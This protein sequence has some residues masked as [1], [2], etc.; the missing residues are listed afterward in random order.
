MK[1]IYETTDYK[2]VAFLTSIGINYSHF[3]ITKDKRMKFFFERHNFGFIRGH[4]CAWVEK[5]SEFFDWA[6]YDIAKAK[7][8]KLKRHYEK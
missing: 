6:K 1:K 8:I 5:N 3:I 2:F 7:I 4:Y